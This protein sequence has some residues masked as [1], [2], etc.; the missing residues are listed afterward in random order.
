MP[1]FFFAVQEHYVRVQVYISY[2][3]LVYEV[4]DYNTFNE[5]DIVRQ[6]PVPSHY[7]VSSQ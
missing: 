2:S 4:L 7:I 5:S 6:R 3:N 1:N